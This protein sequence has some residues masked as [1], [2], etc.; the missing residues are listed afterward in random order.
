ML[1]VYWGVTQFMMR[2]LHVFS[3]GGYPLPSVGGFAWVPM[4]ESTTLAGCFTCNPRELPDDEPA[5]T[6]ACERARI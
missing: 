5:I 1:S 6:R 4:D 3:G 2:F